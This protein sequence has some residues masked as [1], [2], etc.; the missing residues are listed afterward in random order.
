[1]YIKLPLQMIRSHQQRRA[2]TFVLA[3]G[4]TRLRTNPSRAHQAINAIDAALFAQLS[5][6]VADLVVTVH[7]AAFQPRFLDGYQQALVFLG[8]FAFRIQTPSIKTAR[9]SLKH[10]AKPSHR[11]LQRIGLVTQ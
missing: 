9:M 10:F 7:A 3:P 11:D 8:T 6:I 5:Q 4:V 1:M 2:A